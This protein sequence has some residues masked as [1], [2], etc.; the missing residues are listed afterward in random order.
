M[1]QTITGALANI[2][3]P[4]GI[5]PDTGEYGYRKSGADTV[6]PFS[7]GVNNG[8]AGFFWN[9]GSGRRQL[10]IVSGSY[11][12][13]YFSPDDSYQ[14]SVLKPCKI[15]ATFSSTTLSSGHGVDC[16]LFKNNSQVNTHS[17]GGVYTYGVSQAID[18]EEGD[19]FYM[20][21]TVATAPAWSSVT[22]V[23]VG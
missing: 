15:K 17:Y 7:S 8:M 16:Q 9:T 19:T 22:A 10:L 20:C 14:L 3:F 12:T 23:I 11:N 5:D 13:D 18:L 4:F 1:G 21:Q 2:P 6:T